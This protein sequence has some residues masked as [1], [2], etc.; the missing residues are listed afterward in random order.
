MIF[1]LR[2]VNYAAFYL[3]WG[4]CLYLKGGEGIF[5]TFL[6]TG[7][8]VA[9]HFAFVSNHPVREGIFALCMT[10]FGLANESMLSLTGVLSYAEVL[11]AGV[12]W[13]TIVLWFCFSLTY[14]HAFSWLESRL[15][16]ASVLGA[17]AAPVCYSVLAEAGA[18]T[19][20]LNKTTT[21]FFIGLDW[22]VI[23]PSTFAFS[24]WFRREKV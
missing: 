20:L 1:I 23:L 6:V 7:I 12:S 24:R 10:I 22:A 16:L 14:W 9:L 17:I 11:Y 8:Y 15:I 2:L 21:L 4:L 5:V 3:I 13:L 19:F 18:V